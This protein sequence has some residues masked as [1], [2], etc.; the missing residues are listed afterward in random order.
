MTRLLALLVLVAFAGGGYYYWRV[1]PGGAPPRSLDEVSDR[2]KDAGLTASVKTALTLHRS[3]KPYGI[4]VSAEDRVVTLRGVVPAEEFKAAAE[5]VA[6]AVPDV[7]QVVSHIKLDGAVVA[8]PADDPRSLGE[9]LDDEAIEV[10]VR[11]AFSLNRNLAGTRI[12]VESRRKRVRLSGQVASEE[13]RRQA[14]RAAG[15]VAAVEAVTDA[16]AVGRR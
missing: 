7:R 14:V 1:N 9:R 15:E 5:R 16:L 12:E 6:A 10:Q 13:Q 3:L 2:L 8:P 11:M 4:A